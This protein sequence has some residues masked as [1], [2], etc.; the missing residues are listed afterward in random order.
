MYTYIYIYFMCIHEK[1]RQLIG[2]VVMNIDHKF[3]LLM[4][5]LL[6]IHVLCFMKI[7]IYVVLLMLDDADKRMYFGFLLLLCAREFN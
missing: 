5:H 3:W 6:H 4:S 7:S 2:S 1:C